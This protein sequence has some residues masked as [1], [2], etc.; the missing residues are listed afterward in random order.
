MHLLLSIGSGEGR[1][2]VTWNGSV[3]GVLV[4]VD[5]PEAEEEKDA[6]ETFK[7]NYNIFNV[8]FDFFF[9]SE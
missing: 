1:A 9:F 6:G 7:M 2:D 5:I 3:K 8:E 4:I